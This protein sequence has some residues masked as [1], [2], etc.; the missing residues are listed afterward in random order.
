MSKEH[1]NANRLINSTSPYL[2]Q[3][4]YNPV[5]W[6]E[7]GEEALEKA[8]NEDKPILVSIGYSSCHWCH[9]MERESFENDSIAAI[10]NSSFINIKVDREER[11]DVDQVYMDAVQT[12]GQGGGWPLNVFL[13]PDQKPF[14]G[15]TYF[16]PERWTGLLGD[17]STAFKEKREEIE[18]SA[19]L[20]TNRLS[21]S[22]LEKYNLNATNANFNQEGLD[23]LFSTMAT[24]FD[25]SL[26]GMNRAPKFPMPS[27]WLFLM[28]YYASSND[29]K[30]LEQLEL[31]LTEIANGG[32]YDH[33]GGGFARYSVDAKWLVPH[34][35]KMLYD[36]GQLLSLYSE[37]YTITKN[38]QYKEVIYE[39]V[40]WLTREMTSR[41]GA[42]YSALDADSE[43]EEGKF[44]VW[45]YEELQQYLGNDFEIISKYYNI[46][47]GGNW[48]H[49]K[50]ILHKKVSDDEFAK[51]NNIELA[52]LKKLI[53]NTK[54][55]LLKERNKRVKPGLDDKI[56][57][58]WNALMIKGLC[59]AYEAFDDRKLLEMA[60]KN[61]NFIDEKLTQGD[62]L[63]RTYKYSNDKQ[64]KGGAK[65]EAYLEDY[66][67]VID[68]YVALY[69][70]TFDEKWVNKAKAFTDY[71]LEHF[72][73]TEEGVFYFTGNSSEQLIARK[74]EIFDN[75][76]P[77]SNSV[78]A[79]NLN[80][81][82]L[83]FDLE[84]Y[85]SKSA[86]MM[87]KVSD[88]VKSDP[89]FMSNWAILYS[90][91]SSPTAEIAIIGED[92]EKIKQEINQKYNPNKILLGAKES[93]DL[94]LLEEKYAIGDKTTIYV[95]YNKT[96]KLPV[97]DVN[98][99]FKQLE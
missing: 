78:M 56:L 65:I 20:I 45:T 47:Q 10:M 90:Y 72:Y 37:A 74:K 75:V 77:A 88:F 29:Q 2:Q 22:E 14:F 46:E 82:G 91:L 40:D 32:I 71:T 83:I 64:T 81:L 51:A 73:D 99:A 44:Y 94:P 15:G 55:V 41:E 97:H 23:S 24:K 33:V 93:S 98:E 67:L 76:I 39:T 28:R 25:R 36:N 62:K 3:H 66:A 68:A 1:G 48:E 4:A 92:Y 11:P 49:G 42:F 52:D 9:V 43:G 59:D 70:A 34:F 60:L 89:G 12:M 85:R 69:E 17:I 6:Y 19:G 58:G 18:E 26:G 53:N 54:E 61:A 87:S 31:T 84:D 35:E 27:N 80:R 79:V 96:C 95:C 30:A 7:W 13:T 21:L 57:A 50:N 86:D 8:K 5:D 63:Y 16:P 38:E